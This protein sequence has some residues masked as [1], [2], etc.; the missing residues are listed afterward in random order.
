MN[1]S[2]SLYQLGQSIWYDNIQRRLLQNGELAAMIDR[3]E[4][5]GITSNPSIF[6]NAIAKTTAYDSALKPMAWAGWSATDIFWELAIEDIRA[7]AD[8]FKPL[9]VNSDGGDGFVSLEVNPLLAHDADGTYKQALDL[10]QRVHRENL[11]I[12][13]PA[14]KEGVIAIE[15]TIAAGLNINVTLIFSLERYQEVINAYLSGLEQRI[16]QG[17]PIDHI[18]S[19]ASFFVSRVDSKVDP[20]LQ[21]IVDEGSIKSSRAASLLGKAAI[22][23]GKLA[24]E[25]FKKNFTQPKFIELSAKGARLQRPLWASTS[26]KNP[27]Y[28]DVLYLDELIG[29]DTVNTVPP[30]TLVAFLDHGKVELTVEKA[31]DEAHQNLSELE[32]LGI[33]MEQVTLELEN[34]GVGSF[35]NAFQGLI[36]TIEDKAK[37][38]LSEING[39][40]KPLTDQV[41]KLVTDETVKRLFE[42]DPLL[43]TEDPAQQEEIRNRCNWLNSPW[44]APETLREYDALVKYCSDAGITH[45]LLLGMGGSS[46]A[47]EVFSMINGFS[48]QDGKTGLDLAILDSTDPIQVIESF[49]RSDVE[50]TLYI[51]SSKSGGTAEVNAFLDY[52]WDKVEKKLGKKTAEH[53]IAITD[54]GTN[55]EKLAIERKFLRVFTGDPS[56]GG[57]NSALTAFGLV[58][59][60]LIG[61]DLTELIQ[62]ALVISNQ[63]VPEVPFGANP[64]A[65]LGALL[66]TAWSAG[67]DKLTIITD[68]A[69]NSF[70][71]W[72]EQLVAE[73]SGKQGKGII[74]VAQEPLAEI[75][76]YGRDRFFVYLHSI[77]ENT[78]F[79]NSLRKAG[80]AVVELEVSSP[81]DLGGQFYLWEVAI[82][83]ACSIMKVN[84]FNQPDVQDN[85]N[86][87]I[88]KIEG[89]RKDKKLMDCEPKAIIGPVK[90]FGSENLKKRSTSSVNELIFSYLNETV[91]ETDYVA[92]NAYLPRNPETITDLTKL[93]TQILEKFGV[94]TTLG[95]GPRFLHST[96][97]LHKGGPNNGVFI[98]ITADG[99]EDLDIPNEGITFNILE[100][101]QAIGDFEALGARKRRVIR[102]QLNTPDA[103]LLLK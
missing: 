71:S 18:A 90:I 91:K 8:L 11:M 5:F 15:K 25:L 96:G 76:K 69:W 7:A 54:P 66:G 59:A 75:D 65:M 42:V 29:T 47:P 40:A 83:I 17:K 55:L 57:R 48:N 52:C 13:I 73:S 36:L 30:Q 38:A 10:W 74:P 102:I 77:G 56:V 46:L 39:L 103:S 21:K 1:K 82:A 93:R 49:S 31:L 64:G 26:T 78:A 9:F 28:Q 12:K 68:P 98:Q 34:E 100:R 92:I 19:V 79:C 72:L 99:E 3:K 20:Q 23:N 70:G 43:W 45:A 85:K 95:F 14:T 37:T 50:K 63:C 101:A 6:Q 67:K 84:A 2:E 16:K 89:Y 62:N 58:P 80:Q 81:N 41:K 22:S 94:A 51:V 97:Q 53:F 44:A 35:S 60:A 27:A 88:K 32:N 4:I 61:M 33:S 24:Y 86:R 87:T